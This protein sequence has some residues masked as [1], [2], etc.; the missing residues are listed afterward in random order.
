LD[1]LDLD[2]DRVEVGKVE[3]VV[4]GIEAVYL[5]SLKIHLKFIPRGKMQQRNWFQ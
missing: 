4:V 1:E 2:K 3:A 5:T